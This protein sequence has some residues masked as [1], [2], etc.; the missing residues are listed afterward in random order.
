MIK[1]LNPNE[2]RSCSLPLTEA[3]R[4]LP[5]CDRCDRN[6]RDALNDNAY[7]VGRMVR[8]D[9]T[10][11]QRAALEKLP[12]IVLYTLA[13]RGTMIVGL[14]EHESM[15][16]VQ[17]REP[18]AADS[19]IEHVLLDEDGVCKGCGRVHGKPNIETSF[20]HYHPGTQLCHVAHGT[21][22]F[23]VA[24]GVLSFFYERH[25]SEYLVSLLDAAR[26]FNVA[27]MHAACKTWD[28]V[29]DDP[30]SEEYKAHFDEARKY[31]VSYRSIN[32]NGSDFWAEV[33]LALVGMHPDCT[34]QRAHAVVP[35]ID[36]LQTLEEQVF[37]KLAEEVSMLSN[38][39]KREVRDAKSMAGSSILAAVIANMGRR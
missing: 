32:G 16:N 37:K 8:G 39:K 15:R 22:A 3:E 4:D 1:E 2:C 5:L 29:N 6:M 9:I 12:W 34:S 14:S 30:D 25:T 23:S 11:E 20:M 33:S 19:F 13:C 28:R 38:D 24:F 26:D 36:L 27:R 35:E 18:S 10:E 31:L 7:Y 21:D 17:R